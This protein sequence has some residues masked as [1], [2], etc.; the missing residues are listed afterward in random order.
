MCHSADSRPPAPP[1]N[2]LPVHARDLT[3]ESHDGTTF[4]AHLARTEEVGGPGI[5]VMPDVRGLHEFYKDLAVRFADIG[6]NAVAIDYFGRTAGVGDRSE[7]FEYR[8]HVEQVKPEHVAADVRAAVD[9][10]RSPEGGS[11]D[12]VF[13]VGFCM[14]G[15][16]S[17]RQ[18]ADTPGIAGAV[19]FYGRPALA[20]EAVERLS[21]PLLILAAGADKATSVEDV[22]A[23][24]NL[25][26]E[27]GVTTDLVVYENA[28][29]SFFDRS[30]GEHAEAC[31]DAWE[32]IRS[33]VST[34][35]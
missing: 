24:A 20:T 23:F 32:R 15:G 3:L 19:G 17:W 34:T 8:P 22:T 12:R 16:Y 21:A 11:C 14:G 18:A 9:F 26:R 13:T 27:H 1:G 28:P 4:G 31:A 7:A 35:K 10:L 5:V 2:G 25:A 29:H 6:I 30:F 33:F